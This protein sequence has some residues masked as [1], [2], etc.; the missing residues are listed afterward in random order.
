MFSL[1]G[2]VAVVTGGG[3]GLGLAT[4]KRFVGAGASVVMADMRDCSKLA[5]EVG[6]AFVQTDV[7]KEEQVEILMKTAV[8][9]FGPLDV[10]INNAGII[11]P[12]QLID[13]AVV[14]DYEALFR[15]NAL[16]A[17]L[18]IKYG[19]RYMKD[20]GSIV[21]TASNSA[22]GDFSGY[23]AYIASKC[24]VVGITK[25]AAIEYAD[26]RIRVNCICPN[27]IDTPMAYVEG[28]E[29]ELQVVGIITPLARMCKPEE[30]AALFHFL[31]SDDCGYITGEDIY[32]DGGMKAGH[33][34]NK[35]RFIMDAITAA[36]TSVK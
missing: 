11:S 8:E 36:K 2:K 12:E 28:C 4:V 20:G 1:K 24:A 9:I 34:D 26:R 3:S 25:A 15:V 32:I 30:A 7:T 27:T 6:C 10:V 5:E 21:N 17:L 13:D 31:A 35:I 14:E 22:N 18:G 29:T 19:A 33:G 23:G 16:G